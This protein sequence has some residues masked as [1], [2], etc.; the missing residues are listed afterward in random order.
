MNITLK[1][2]FSSLVQ[3]CENFSV[4]V[5]ELPQSCVLPLKCFIIAKSLSWRV[6]D[7]VSLS[8]ILGAIE[9]I[10]EIA[11]VSIS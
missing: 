6:E 11:G 3:D 5:M 4:F 9:W 1:E 2:Q 7:I 10:M 8:W